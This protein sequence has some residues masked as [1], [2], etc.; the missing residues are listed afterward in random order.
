MK[1]NLKTILIA[2]NII[3]LLM[4]FTLISFATYVFLNPDVVVDWLAHFMVEED[5]L[6]NAEVIVVIGGEEN[7]LRLEYG[8]ELLEQGYAQ[9]IVFSGVGNEDY[10]YDLLA[11]KGISQDQYY[12]EQTATTTFENAYNLIP[13][14]RENNFQSMILVSSPVQSRRARFM[15]KKVFP[16]LTVIS[17]F[18]PDSLYNPDLIFEDKSIRQQMSTEVTKSL[19]YYMKY[20]FY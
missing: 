9:K 16:D 19:Y 1:K 13:Y 12:F 2:A 14:I 5:P 6:Q 18:S 11:E 17:S 3:Q 8:V 4:F 7:K 20:A 15:F 10:A